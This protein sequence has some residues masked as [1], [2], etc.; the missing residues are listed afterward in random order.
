MAKAKKKK[1][2]KLSKRITKAAKEFKSFM[3]KLKRDSIKINYSRVLVADNW[4]E[5]TSLYDFYRGLPSHLKQ[6]AGIIA[7]NSL[8]EVDKLK[9]SDLLSRLKSIYKDIRE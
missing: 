1:V 6:I 3:S 2:K 8:K 5:D 4:G 9:P 7:V